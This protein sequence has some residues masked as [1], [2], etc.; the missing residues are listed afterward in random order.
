MC[1]R[2]RIK[3][4]LEFEIIFRRCLKF[5]YWNQFTR[6]VTHVHTSVEHQGRQRVS[7]VLVRR[8][9]LVVL[10]D[11]WNVEWSKQRVVLYVRHHEVRPA[12]RKFGLGRKNIQWWLKNFS[13]SDFEK[14]STA[15][16]RRK[17]YRGRKK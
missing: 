4:P 10:S 15:K 1:K 2:E 11:P 13:D 16:R 8:I 9:T 17:K 12:E 5:N 7:T 3:T 14:V 6:P